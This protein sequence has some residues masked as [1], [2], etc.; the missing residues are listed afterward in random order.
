VIDTFS[1]STFDTFAAPALLGAT[2]LR[3]LVRTPEAGVI[4]GE[5]S[6]VTKIFAIIKM[7]LPIIGA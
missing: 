1:A 3:T 2:M 4:T 7:S 5:H 6:A